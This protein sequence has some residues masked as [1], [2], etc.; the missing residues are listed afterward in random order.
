LGYFPPIFCSACRTS[1][2]C[3]S[4]SLS[5]P[6]VDGMKEMRFFPFSSSGTGRDLPSPFPSLG[7]I[8]EHQRSEPFRPL[9][10]GQEEVAWA[11]FFFPQKIL[12]ESPPSL[13][14]SSHGE[15]E[16]LRLCWSPLRP[17]FF[18]LGGT[19]RKQ[20]FFFPFFS[21]WKIFD[22]PLLSSTAGANPPLSYALLVF[23]GAAAR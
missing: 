12:A 21:L 16:A 17:V 11:P 7:A 1:P 10:E 6:R 4:P 15:L 18:P 22:F 14:F 13:P 8:K 20:S 5:L 19:Q 3:S 9:W 2:P 23:S